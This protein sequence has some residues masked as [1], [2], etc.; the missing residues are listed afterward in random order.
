MNKIKRISC[1]EKIPCFIG[2]YYLSDHSFHYAKL[3]TK[4]YDYGRIMENIV[5]IKSNEK[6]YIQVSDDISSDSTFDREVD[7]RFR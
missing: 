7:P 4:N 2:K 1:D 6:I 5:A 3:G